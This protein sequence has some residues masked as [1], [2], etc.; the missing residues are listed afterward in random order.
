MDEGTLK[1]RELGIQFFSYHVSG[2]PHVF[3]LINASG[4]LLMLNSFACQ[5]EFLWIFLVN[6]LHLMCVQYDS[7][8]EQ[9]CKFL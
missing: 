7:D 6:S 8:V 3:F 4:F 2:T 9:S 5:M 1:L